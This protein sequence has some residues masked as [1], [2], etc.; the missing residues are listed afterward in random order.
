MQTSMLMMTSFNAGYL[1]FCE[2][3]RTETV[4]NSIVAIDVKAKTVYTVVSGADFYTR[5]PINTGS[6]RQVMVCWIQ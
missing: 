3:H 4:A 2:N 1:P 5:P 6:G